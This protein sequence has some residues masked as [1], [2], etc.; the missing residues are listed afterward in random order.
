MITVTHDSVTGQYKCDQSFTLVGAN[1]RRCNGIEWSGK[2]PV[3]LKGKSF[4]I[5]DMT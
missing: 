2:E 4:I 5:E 1:I 3:C